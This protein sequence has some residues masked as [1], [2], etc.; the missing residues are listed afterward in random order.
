MLFTQRM[1]VSRVQARLQEL[2]AELSSCLKVKED[3]SPRRVHRLRTTIRR[4]DSLLSF[5]AAKF[6]KKQQSVLDELAAV[7]KRAGKVRDLDVQIALLHEIA[8]GSTVADRRTVQELLTEKRQQ[9]AAK[10]ASKARTFTSSRLFAHFK[11]MSE[12]LVR[13]N[14]V[15]TN[16][17]REAEARISELR[18]HFDPGKKIKPRRLHTLRIELKSIR[19][20][21]E[22]NEG[23][24]ERDQLLE[25]L[26]AV[27][28]A[29]GSWHDWEQLTKTTKK[30]FSERSSCPLVQEMGALLAAKH[31]AALSATAYFFSS[32]EASTTRKPPQT[33]RRRMVLAQRAG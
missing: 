6:S 26:K 24:S 17:L 21:T 27:Q 16:P 2:S 22:L 33:A 31:S 12:T 28:D 9:H 29:I 1:A 7:R 19:Y 30:R 25:R 18:A 20:L 32:S 5:A 10:L 23:S 4:I 8:N 15:E 11:R 13:D 3:F 14:S